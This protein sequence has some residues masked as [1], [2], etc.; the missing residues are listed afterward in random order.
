MDWAGMLKKNRSYRRFISKDIPN[1]ELIEILEQNRFIASPHNMQEL[2]YFIVK[3]EADAIFQEVKWAALITEH[4]GPKFD[5]RPPVYIVIVRDSQ[6][7]ANAAALWCEVGI[8]SQTILLSAIEKGY[9]GCCLGAFRE[10]RV[11]KILGLSEDVVPLLI[12]ALGQPKEDVHIVPA[13]TG[14]SLKYYKNEKSAHYVPKLEV[15]DLI[16]NYR[17]FFQ[18]Y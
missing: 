2:R 8:A 12:I 17:E 15:E 11:R 13:K 6:S 9:G 10:D 4:E 5:E 7:K 16:L 18:T 14:D 3:N 1:K